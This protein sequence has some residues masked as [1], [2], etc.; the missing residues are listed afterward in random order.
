MA[1][2]KAFDLGARGAFSNSTFTQLKSHLNKSSHESTSTM[3]RKIVLLADGT[4]NAF[5][6]QESNVWRLYDALDQSKPDQI[7][8]YIKGVGTSGFKPFAII[9]GATGVGVPSN[10]RKLY[11][12]PCWNWKPGDEVYMFGFSR[13]SFT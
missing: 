7:S 1:S 9:D 12:F 5:T 8:Y 4:G 6:T 2:R 13:G 3:P 10:V 11:R